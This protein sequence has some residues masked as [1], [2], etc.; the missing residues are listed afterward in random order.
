MKGNNKINSSAIFLFPHQDDEVG[1]FQKILDEQNQGNE[2][3]CLYFTRSLED[4]K[5]L[6][7]ELESQKVLLDYGVKSQN[8]LFVGRLLGIIDKNLCS[9]ILEVKKWL[10]CWLANH[11]FVSN[12]YVPAWEGGHPDHD[13]LNAIAAT[14]INQENFKNKVWQFPLYNSYKCPPYF[15][16]IQSILRENGV[17]N[18]TPISFTNRFRFVR[19]CLKYPSEWLAWVGLFPFFCFNYIFLGKQI[20]QPIQLK[21]LE[22]RPHAGRLYYEVR[23]FKTWQEVFDA[24]N[25]L[26]K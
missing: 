21:R 6:T 9:H 25:S 20:L 24:I 2:V 4:K 12:I 11:F 13:C 5:N 23:N 15:Y 22:Y 3:F 8:I 17:T 19:S 1:I 16:K 26:P 10:D 18:I 7:R 14:L